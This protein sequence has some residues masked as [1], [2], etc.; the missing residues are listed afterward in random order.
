MV[1]G[2]LERKDIGFK[3]FRIVFLMI[4]VLAAMIF[5]FSRFSD[6]GLLSEEG[7]HLPEVLMYVCAALLLPALTAA[8]PACLFFLWSARARKFDIW[9]WSA[10]VLAFVS[11][12]VLIFVFSF[13]LGPD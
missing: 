3:V 5:G 6:T 12:V 10:V 8:V 1:G 13:K 7:S 2:F 9:K 4:L 11:V